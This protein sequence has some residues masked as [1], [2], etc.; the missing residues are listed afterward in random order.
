LG[1]TTAE[2]DTNDPRHAARFDFHAALQHAHDDTLATLTQ[3]ARI[4]TFRRERLSAHCN[5][6]IIIGKKIQILRHLI[7]KGPAANQ[8]DLGLETPVGFHRL[9]DR[10]DALDIQNRGRLALNLDAGDGL[11][12]GRCQQGNDHPRYRTNDGEQQDQ[13][14]HLDDAGEEPAIAQQCIIAT[15]CGGW[16]VI[17]AEQ[18]VFVS[19]IVQHSGPRIAIHHI[20]TPLSKMLVRSARQAVLH[21]GAA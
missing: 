20:H 11:I 16:A 2:D 9:F 7:G 5:D 17:F 10:L 6:E 12:G 18:R 19:G 13:L 8:F 4:D 15:R 3:L 14:P 1:G 21:A